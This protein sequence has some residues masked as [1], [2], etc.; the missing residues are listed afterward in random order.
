MSNA[1]YYE[2][3]GAVFREQKGKPHEIYYGKGQ[4]QP[5]KVMSAE[6]AG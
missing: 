5:I 1:V 2:V 4:W 6:F 3:E